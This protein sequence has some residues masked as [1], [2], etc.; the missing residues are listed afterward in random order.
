MDGGGAERV[1][2][3]IMRHLV[4]AGHEV[5][6]V[7]AFGGGVLLPL[8]PAGVKLVEL[9]SS[10]LA[11]SGVGLM[12][13]LKAERPW[14][15]QAIMWPCTVIAVAAKFL[16]RSTTKLVLSDH[17]FLS[18]HYAGTRN[19]LA[20]RLSMSLLYPRAEH[21]V[22]ASKGA[23]ADVAKL[24]GLP[25]HAVEAI[26]NPVALPDAVAS[27]AETR[28]A[29]SGA[30]PRIIS[31]GSFKAEKNHELLIQ[32]FAL[33][34][35]QYPDARLII[36]GDGALR[37]KLEA[38][39]DRLGLRDQVVLP[40]FQLDPWPFY[41]DA[42]LFVLSSDYE[43]MSLVLVEALHAGLRIVSTDCEAGPAELLEG[44]RFGRLVPVG[45]ANALCRAMLDELIEPPNPERQRAR[46]LAI[47]GPAALQRYEE[48]L[49]G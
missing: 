27:T 29:W 43:G 39:R 36:L 5:H 20:L 30:S 12:R 32:A 33:V 2:L 44:G 4:A 15:L 35:R 3:E 46:A 6:L 7:L 47:S 24:A 16:A 9:R 45:D 25:P 26:Y 49:A 40:G 14:S 37:V 34:A 31:A 28:Q 41:A 19:R 18:D 1:Q 11:V 42:D 13:Y 8:V 10:R 23:A 17:T 21:R 22:A 38:L 48:L